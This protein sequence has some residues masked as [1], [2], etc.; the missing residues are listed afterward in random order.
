MEEGDDAREHT[1]KFHTIVNRLAE[2]EVDIHPDLLSTILLRCLPKSYENF[3]CAMISR[4]ELPTPEIL[5]KK[6]R[7]KATHER[8]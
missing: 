7:K 3:R 2:M 1:R 6:F 4:D 5:R 8:P